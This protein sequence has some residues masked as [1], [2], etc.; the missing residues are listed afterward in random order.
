VSIVIPTRDGAATL[1]ALLAS[2]R[3]QRY[4]GHVE[5]VAVDSGS[6][7]GTCGL[8]ERE[9]DAV[10][11]IEPEKFDHGLTR[12]LGMARTAGPLVVLTVQDAT[13]ASEHWLSALVEP[14]HSD[15][16]VAGSFARQV[17]RPDAS[18]VSRESLARWVAAATEPRTVAV[19]VD[20]FHS[21]SPMERL[22]HCAF[23]NVCACIR[24][25]VWRHHPF[26][27]TAI[28]EDIAWAHEVL[29]AGHRLAYA[30]E[31][32]VVH[33]HDRPLLYEFRRT[34]ELHQRLYDL[35]DLQ[36]IPSLHHL[37]RAIAATTRTHLRWEPALRHR[38]RA[39]GLALVWPVAQYLGGRDGVR[40]R[41]RRDTNPA[42]AS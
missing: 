8:L 25:D 7:D 31:A 15:Q 39:L 13:P 34:R 10:V 35:F 40:A 29:L 1:P 37:A 36:T 9:A 20:Q 16:R 3:A 6:T 27:A 14:L 23:D 26:R 22:Y 19:D 42:C 4:E 28:G 24:R 30:P 2:I 11:Q 41:Q 32:V 38:P 33:S 21:M 18:G 17:A 12:N 5:I